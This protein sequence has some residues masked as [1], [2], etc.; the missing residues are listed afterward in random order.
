M[1]LGYGPIKRKRTVVD[2]KEKRKKRMKAMA[3]NINS[4]I[5]LETDGYL[6]KSKD[7][8]HSGKSMEEIG[9]YEAGSTKGG[10]A[11]D[12]VSGSDTN[13]ISAKV[14]EQPRR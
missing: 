10:N 6:E 4:N 5:V 13:I 8:F 9:K 3:L 12:L 1:H 2:T 14:A 7:D 11:S